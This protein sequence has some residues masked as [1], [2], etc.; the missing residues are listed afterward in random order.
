MASRTP[1]R[2]TTSLW[3]T[4]PSSNPG[5]EGDPSAFHSELFSADIFNSITNANL[6]GEAR[7]I[8]IMPPV[9]SPVRTST[10]SVSRA[11][12][13]RSSSKAPSTP[14]LQKVKGQ[15]VRSMKNFAILSHIQ[16][17]RLGEASY[18]HLADIVINELVED[19]PSPSKQ[20]TN[21]KDLRRRVFDCLNIMVSLGYAIKIAPPG[22]S[23]LPEEQAIEE[24][25]NSSN[26]YN[27]WIRW[28]GES[29]TAIG[30]QEG[31]SGGLQ[32]ELGLC[33]QQI[34]QQRHQLQENLLKYI[35]FRRLLRRNKALQKSIPKRE[36]L[37]VP[38]LL[39]SVP[40][41]TNIEVNIDSSSKQSVAFSFDGTFELHDEADVLQR[42]GLQLVN[43]PVPYAAS[44]TAVTR[45]EDEDGD[46]EDSGEKNALVHEEGV[47]VS[48]DVPGMMQSSYL[49]YLYT[50]STPER[51]S[52]SQEKSDD[53]GNDITKDAVCAATVQPQ[54][55]YFP[56]SSF[57]TPSRSR[58]QMH[59]N[60]VSRETLSPAARRFL[61]K[62]EQSRSPP[63]QHR[64]YSSA[65]TD[66]MDASPSSNAAV[67][68]RRPK[69]LLDDDSA[70]DTA[71]ASLI[72]NSQKRRKLRPPPPRPELTPDDKANENSNGRE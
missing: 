3:A 22:N 15:T 71:L 1:P 38:F 72:P 12:P 56:E 19:E 20:G 28:R 33:R 31:V 30:S 44:P 9:S 14:D 47:P 11:T 17:K 57:Q 39:I 42:M 26:M 40:S 7:E 49:Q 54:E 10:S 21:S 58:T 24:S 64:E 45:D 59:R 23:I 68:G 16:L 35:A 55:S 69:R 37:K 29:S 32:E 62:L 13:Q 2:R 18:G 63:A 36:K 46:G 41:S 8:G 6:D 48:K 27:R 50:P 66:P 34:Q 53:D 65:F 61:Q 51:K 67:E 5:L 43:G 70:E 25:F 4:S 52:A 60:A